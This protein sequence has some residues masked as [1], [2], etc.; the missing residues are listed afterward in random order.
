MNRIS[1]T[2]WCARGRRAKRSA[3]GARRA[4]HSVLEFAPGICHP[5]R[6]HRFGR[7]GKSSAHQFLAALCRILYGLAGSQLCD[8]DLEMQVGG[9]H[10]GPL[11]SAP[12]CHMCS[13]G[14]SLLPVMCRALACG[15]CPVMQAAH[16]ARPPPCCDTQGYGDDSVSVGSF[17]SAAFG[18]EQGMVWWTLLIVLAFCVCFRCEWK[19]G[20]PV[21]DL[22]W[23][24]QVASG[25]PPGA[26]GSKC[27]RTRHVLEAAS[28]CM[29]RQVWQPCRRLQLSYQTAQAACLC[30]QSWPWPRC[31]RSISRSDNAR[32][33][34]PS[35]ITR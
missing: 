33:V 18:Y 1:P 21:P 7:R 23:L 30:L 15:C 31:P 29:P 22:C 17:M 14:P 2:T 28:C 12:P 3:A 13:P 20:V 25:G 8:R 16:R 4:Q 24:G 19:S 32:M 10:G 11:S 26:S 5:V 34:L 35:G 6:L 27:A 9:V